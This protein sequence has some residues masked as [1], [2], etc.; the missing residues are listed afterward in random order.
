MKQ[1]IVNF[2]SKQRSELDA[3]KDE[4]I[5]HTK[6]TNQIVATVMNELTNQMGTMVSS[7]KAEHET[8]ITKLNELLTSSREQVSALGD[9]KSALE[10]ELDRIK[11]DLDYV[12][13]TRTTLDGELKTTQTELTTASAQVKS[14][15]SELLRKMGEITQLKQQLAENRRV[16]IKFI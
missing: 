7:L 13:K 5:E 2:I 4:H 9:E 3:L 1:Y 8:E 16:L 10:S 11:N 6:T 14:L 12:T 15:K